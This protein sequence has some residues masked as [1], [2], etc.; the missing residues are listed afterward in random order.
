M[1]TTPTARTT[2]AITADAIWQVLE[3]LGWEHKS[4]T[5]LHQFVSGTLEIEMD[6]VGGWIHIGR[7][8]EI[9]ADI[10]ILESAMHGIVVAME[11]KLI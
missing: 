10:A 8:K 11:R 6:D 5:R 7:I 2:G 9:Y 4:H 1:T 3:P